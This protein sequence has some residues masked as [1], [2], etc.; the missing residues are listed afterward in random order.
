[1]V[2]ISILPHFQ[3]SMNLLCTASLLTGYYFI[4]KENKEAH[5]KCMVTAL[6]ASAIFLVSYLYY[7]YNVGTYRFGGVGS[8]RTVYFTILLTHTVLSVVMLPMIALTVYRAYRQDFERHPKIAR[9]TLPIWLYVSV[10]GIIIYTM[11][12]HLYPPISPIIDVA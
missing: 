3:A 11:L 12:Y 1:M 5:M 2:D 4:K 7:H 9:W 6:T 8:I 10:T